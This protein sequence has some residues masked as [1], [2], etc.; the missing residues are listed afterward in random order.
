MTGNGDLHVATV[1]AHRVVRAGNS[2]W[3]VT[4]SPHYERQRCPVFVF[5]CVGFFTAWLACSVSEQL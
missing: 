4:D 3:S 2:L 5:V 1:L